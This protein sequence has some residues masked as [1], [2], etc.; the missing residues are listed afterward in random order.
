MD[1]DKVI[2]DSE[3]NEKDIEENKD[4]VITHAR[5]IK[6]IKVC[7]TLN[8]DLSGSIV[9]LN[10]ARAKIELTTISEMAS[11]NEGLVHSGYIYSSISYAALVVINNP[12]AIITSSNI[13]YLSAI[14][15]GKKITIDA[16]VKNKGSKKSIV[17]ITVKLADLDIADGTMTIFTLDKHPLS[18]NLTRLL[19]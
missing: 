4:N 7:K 10:E 14:S 17:N 11:D 12:N 16:V 1:V 3:Q 15:V 18:I 5:D 8:S 19:D 6:R 2:E 9:E 13:N